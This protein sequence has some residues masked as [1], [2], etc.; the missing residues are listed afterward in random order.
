MWRRLA[1]YAGAPNQPDWVQFWKLIS[2]RWLQTGHSAD[3]LPQF[4]R[5]D[6][7]HIWQVL[8]G[9]SNCSYTSPSSYSATLPYAQQPCDSFS[10]YQCNLQTS[11]PIAPIPGQQGTQGGRNNAEYLH[12]ANDNKS[13]QAPNY[14]SEAAKPLDNRQLKKQ[15]KQ[16]VIDWLRSYLQEEPDCDMWQGLAAAG[17]QDQPDWVQFWK[18]ISEK[19]LQT[20]HSA[21]ELPLTLYTLLEVDE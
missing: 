19:W 1:T 7:I 13:L 18:I 15:K 3:E 21:D 11:A 6:C 4:N 9:T 8:N 5:Q 14:A 20:G 12:T 16:Q 17:A 2:E 10:N